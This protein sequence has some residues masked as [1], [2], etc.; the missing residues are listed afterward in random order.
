MR[1]VE[2]RQMLVAMARRIRPIQSVGTPSSSR[3]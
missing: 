1:V 3:R 2:K